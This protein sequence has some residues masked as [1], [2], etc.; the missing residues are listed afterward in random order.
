M[1]PPEVQV[2]FA[3]VIFR[4]SGDAEENIRPKKKDPRT[5]SGPGWAVYRAIQPFDQEGF[6]LYLLDF[7]A[8]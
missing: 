8:S 3:L 6:P 7:S 2:V 5:D 4:V 1:R